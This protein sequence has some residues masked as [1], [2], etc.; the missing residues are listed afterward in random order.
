[1]LICRELDIVNIKIRANVH[2]VACVICANSGGIYTMTFS[3]KN[4]KICLHFTH[5]FTQI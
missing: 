3:C 4:E 5:T 1:M 2:S